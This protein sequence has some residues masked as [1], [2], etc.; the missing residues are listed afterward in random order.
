VIPVNEHFLRLVEAGRQRQSATAARYARSL[1][2]AVVERA[3]ML[4]DVAIE[5]L[6]EFIVWVRESPAAA[7]G[8]LEGPQEIVCHRRRGPGGLERLVIE[9]AARKG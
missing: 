6:W 3:G 1:A 4:D 2:T 7:R 9:S 8:W 5:G